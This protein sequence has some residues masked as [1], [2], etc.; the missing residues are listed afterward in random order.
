L[1]TQRAEGRSA[2][3]I[4]EIKGERQAAFQMAQQLKEPLTSQDG[5]ALSAD[6]VTFQLSDTKKGS[7]P[8]QATPLSTRADW[9]YTSS[10]AGDADTFVLTYRMAENEDALAGIYKSQIG[11]FLES[12]AERDS[13]E[14]LGFEVEIARQFDLN[15]TPETGGVIEFHDLKAQEPPKRSEVL[16]E[17]KSNIGKEYQVSQQLVSALVNKEGTAIP[18]KNFTLKEET[19]LPFLSGPTEV[20]AGDLILFVSDKAGSSDQFKVIYELIPSIDI[21]AGD[22]TARVMYSISEI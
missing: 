6:A 22:Y 15:V 17:V 1:N 12:G 21:P 8:T 9:V 10:P 3:V 4:V 19:V 16:I 5:R 18:E 20:K 13:L 11:Y 14:V 2:D 7:G